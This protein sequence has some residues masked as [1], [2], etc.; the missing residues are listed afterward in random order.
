MARHATSCACEFQPDLAVGAVKATN[1]PAA[2]RGKNPMSMGMSRS[3]DKSEEQYEAPERSKPAKPVIA[4]IESYKSPEPMQ[5]AFVSQLKFLGVAP[6]QAKK[7]RTI[8]D[9]YI[10]LADWLSDPNIP[11]RDGI[12]REIEELKPALR[13]IED[14]L[15]PKARRYLQGIREALVENTASN[16]HRKRRRNAEAL[17]A[18]SAAPLAKKKWATFGGMRNWIF[19]GVALVGGFIIY[20]K[21]LAKGPKGSPPLKNVTPTQGGGSSGGKMRVTANQV[22]QTTSSDIAAGKKNPAYSYAKVIN[23]SGNTKEFVPS[24]SGTFTGKLLQ[25]GNTLWAEIAP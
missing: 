15:E 23:V 18:A 12:K 20:K 24:V 1:M 16:P 17:P 2:K 8:Y 6:A 11:N 10:Q 9:H 14:S 13:G 7:I 22:S 25:E 19:L 21:F 3:R 5:D 4:P